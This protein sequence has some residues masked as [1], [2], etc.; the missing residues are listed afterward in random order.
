MKIKNQSSMPNKYLFLI[1]VL[2]CL[3]LLGI[4]QLVDTGGPLRFIANYTVV[5]MQKGI[6]YAGMWLSDMSDNFETMEEMK[7]ENKELQSKVDEL[8][9]ENTKLRQEQYE[10]ERLRE[11]YKL[12]ENY[13]DYKK[14]G[15]H[16]IANNGSNWFSDFTIDKGS[17]DGIKV[18]CNVMA[19]SG[20]VGIVT[21]VGPDYARVRSIIDDSSNISA[22]TLSTSDTCIVRGDLELIADGRIRFEKLANND[23]K[24]EV[25]EQV[26]TSHVSNRFVQG[27]FIGYISEIEV[28]S[29]NLTRSGYITPAVDFSKLQEVLVITETKQEMLDSKTDTDNDA[30]NSDE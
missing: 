24:I 3:I 23:N 13:S 10:L 25:G 18:N 9:I 22:M 8:T 2:V 16:V 20:L 30:G 7:K 28:D 11:L 14:I 17:N 6:S 5:P 29:N 27:L 19:G 1:L 4:E 26:V 12:D 15:A 21:E